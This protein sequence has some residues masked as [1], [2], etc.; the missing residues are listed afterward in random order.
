MKTARTLLALTVTVAAINL[1]M[2]ILAVTHLASINHHTE[3]LAA[4]PA[5]AAFPSFGG[6]PLANPSYAGGGF[7]VRQ[8]NAA[9]ATAYRNAFGGAP[10]GSG[11]NGDGAVYNDANGPVAADPADVANPYA[12]T[13]N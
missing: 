7:G 3:N 2:A 9:N 11:G 12:D 13:G 5:L 6:V 4:T 10:G 8:P 1:L